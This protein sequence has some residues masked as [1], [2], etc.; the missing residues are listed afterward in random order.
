MSTSILQHVPLELQSLEP[1]A[2]DKEVQPRPV[3][4]FMEPFLEW[5]NQ[6]TWNEHGM[7]HTS[8]QTKVP[9]IDASLFLRFTSCEG[10]S[11]LPS[12]ALTLACSKRFPNK[13]GMNAPHLIPIFGR[14]EESNA[15]CRSWLPFFYRRNVSVQKGRLW[16]VCFPHSRIPGQG[17][18]TALKLKVGRWP[19]HVG[20]CQAIPSVYTVY[21]F[22]R[23][24]SQMLWIWEFGTLSN[25][26]F[27]QVSARVGK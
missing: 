1:S 27:L 6:W 7:N 8:S 26:F 4:W 25:E 14:S 23:G 3:C 15:K 20:R 2:G 24:S 16:D 11:T 10:F 17:S 22:W 12:R 5:M 19:L 13:K 9:K 18:R 21:T